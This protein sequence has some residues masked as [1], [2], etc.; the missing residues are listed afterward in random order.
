MGPALPPS[1]GPG[2]VGAARGHEAS[3]G[4]G[5]PVSWAPG[6]HAGEDE[7]ATLVAVFMG[8]SWTG[9]NE[10]QTALYPHL[11]R[12]PGALTQPLGRTQ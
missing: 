8:T 10:R 12:S 7:W 5:S 6:P 4:S 11:P 2:P 1:Q 3:S 9:F